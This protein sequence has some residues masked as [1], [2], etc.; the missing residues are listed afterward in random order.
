MPS[1]ESVQCSVNHCLV[2]TCWLLHIVSYEIVHA[3]RDV[4]INVVPGEESARHV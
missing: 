4:H 1:G 2:E 3:R